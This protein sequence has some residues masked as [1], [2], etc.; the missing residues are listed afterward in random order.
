M[1]NEKGV[2]RITANHRAAQRGGAARA[3]KSRAIA[4]DENR[5]HM[6]TSAL[7]QSGASIAWQGRNFRMRHYCYDQE[8]S[9]LKGQK[10]KSVAALGLHMCNNSCGKECQEASCVAPACSNNSLVLCRHLH[11]T[12]MWHQPYQQQLHFQHQQLLAAVVTA[13]FCLLLNRHYTQFSLRALS[14]FKSGLDCIKKASSSPTCTLLLVCCSVWQCVA[15]RR[16]H[17]GPRCT[18]TT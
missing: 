7:C 12:A 1:F 13:N 14:L 2:P 4:M 9:G 5:S 3:T 15:S 10:T 16:H 18:C 8:R 6:C 17:Q 11:Y